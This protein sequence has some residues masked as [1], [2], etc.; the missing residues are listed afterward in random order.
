MFAGA[1]A[2][3]MA[4]VTRG[5]VRRVTSIGDDLRIDLDPAPNQ[6]P[7]EEA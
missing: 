6:P 5:R 3:S 4:A 2:P 1:G 7:N